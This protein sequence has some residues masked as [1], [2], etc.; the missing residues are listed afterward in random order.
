MKTGVVLPVKDEGMGELG[1]PGAACHYARNLIL[2]RLSMSNALT[3]RYRIM[4]E[5]D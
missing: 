3:E 4:Q 1:L 5:R 2:Q